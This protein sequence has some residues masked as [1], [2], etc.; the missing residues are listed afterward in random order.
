[1]IFLWFLP[2]DFFAV[3]IYFSVSRNKISKGGFLNEN[4]IK[5]YTS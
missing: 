5:K 1:M 3:R 2:I 4:N